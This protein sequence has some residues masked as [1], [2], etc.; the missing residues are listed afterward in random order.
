MM[1]WVSDEELEMLAIQYRADSELRE[2]YETFVEYVLHYI[3][4]QKEGK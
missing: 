4:T 3:N 1:N 2:K